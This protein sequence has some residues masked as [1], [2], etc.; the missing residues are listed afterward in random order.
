MG[1]AG[2]RAKGRAYFARRIW[3]GPDHTKWHVWLAP[4]PRHCFSRDPRPMLTFVQLHGLGT[5]Q[6]TVRVDALDERIMEDGALEGFFVESR[7]ERESSPDW[8]K[9]SSKPLTAL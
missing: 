8:L 1:E 5:E 7:N 9:R 6:I 4:A 2:N 3:D